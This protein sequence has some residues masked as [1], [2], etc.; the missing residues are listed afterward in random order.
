M[1]NHQATRGPTNHDLWACCI[2]VTF[3]RHWSPWESKGS[4]ATLMEKN[5]WRPCATL[6]INS[7]HPSDRLLV[8]MFLT[9]SQTRYR[10]DVTYNT[11]CGLFYIF[12]G[13]LTSFTIFVWRS[14]LSIKN[15]MV[16][17]ETISNIRMKLIQTYFIFGL[18]IWDCRKIEIRKYSTEEYRILKLG[19]TS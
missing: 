4:A 9:T 18:L 13:F 1:A 14:T 17:I 16:R 3:A 19:R 8:S 7:R 15:R 5:S 2:W 11:F 12:R 6:K 10:I